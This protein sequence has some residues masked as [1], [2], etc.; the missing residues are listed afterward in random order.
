[1]V[2]ITPRIHPIGVLLSYH[3]LAGPPEDDEIAALEFAQN[4]LHIVKVSECV[5]NHN[6]VEAGLRL[7]TIEA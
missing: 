7:G 3:E 6:Q 5:L 1:L 4:F 2:F